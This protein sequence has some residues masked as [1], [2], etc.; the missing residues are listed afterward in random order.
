M[1]CTL[2]RVLLDRERAS[3][4]QKADLEARVRQGEI[5]LQRGRERC[6]EL[7]KMLSEVNGARIKLEASLAQAA[8]HEQ[9]LCHELDL[10]RDRTTKTEAQ[11]ASLYS[12]NETL[13]NLLSEADSSSPDSNA[14]PFSVQEVLLENKQR[15]QMIFELNSTI[16]RHEQTIQELRIALQD[17]LGE[18]TSYQDDHCGAVTE[19]EDDGTTQFDSI[20]E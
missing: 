4:D 1:V 13:L 12:I 3:M 16:R 19:I 10:L 9:S 2:V 8:Q 15:R 18:S 11:Y 7:E 20:A 17:V 14:R 6:M 5:E